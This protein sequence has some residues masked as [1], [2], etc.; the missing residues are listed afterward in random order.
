MAGV[1][2][3]VVFLGGAGAAC[4]YYFSSSLP[5]GYMALM[6]TSQPASVQ[7]GEKSPAAWPLN[8][9]KGRKTLISS[10]GCLNPATLSEE[11]LIL[12]GTCCLLGNE[13]STGVFVC[14][15]FSVPG[16]GGP[17]CGGWAPG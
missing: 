6:W 15:G 8:E 1:G 17:G 2:G 14:L 3:G 11:D 13:H 16:R 12:M 5:D 7:R 9:G 4:P 10:E